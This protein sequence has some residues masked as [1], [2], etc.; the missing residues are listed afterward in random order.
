MATPR[1]ARK[2]EVKANEDLITK[3][4]VETIR[5]DPDDFYK[6]LVASRK[7]EEFLTEHQVPFDTLDAARTYYS[8]ARAFYYTK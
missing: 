3:S 1:R 7:I 6:R 4:M 2:C 5:R 8:Q